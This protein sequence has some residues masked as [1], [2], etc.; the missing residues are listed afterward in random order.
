MINET[1][2]TIRGNVATSPVMRVTTTM[3]TIV[4]SFRIAVTSK[5]YSNEEK[6]LVDVETSF[7]T[8]TCWRTLAEHVVASV[9]K[10]DGV[11][12]TGRLRVREFLHEGVQRTSA[13]IVADSVGHDL[14]WGTTSLSR[15]IRVER[16]SPD[17]VEADQLADEVSL[18]PIE[19]EGPVA[20][21]V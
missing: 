3:S 8:V 19:D 18:T 11:L 4:C 7:Y 14:M 6:K 9:N 12:V 20:A 21:L 5:R 15:S 1:S 10:G 16:L 2:V 17:E 13:D